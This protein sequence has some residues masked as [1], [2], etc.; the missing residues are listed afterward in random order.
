MPWEA[1]GR[2]RDPQ[3][4]SLAVGPPG[5]GRVEVE[6]ME[7]VRELREQFIGTGGSSEDFERCGRGGLR[8]E[9][10]G[11]Q[12]GSTKPDEARATTELIRKG[13]LIEYHAYDDRRRGQGVALVRFEEWVDL[14]ELKFRGTHLASADEYYELLGEQESEDGKDLL[15]LLLEQRVTLQACRGERGTH[16]SHHEVATGVSPDF[17]RWGVRIRRSPGPLAEGAE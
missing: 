10:G 12:D 1:P 11:V 14:G 6:L 8:L 17:D 13:S 7:L 15:P 5:G 2:E 9:D 4:H 16:H 3:L